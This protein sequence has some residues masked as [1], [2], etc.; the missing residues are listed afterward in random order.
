MYIIYYIKLKFIPLKT[1]IKK[2]YFVSSVYHAF[3]TPIVT[4]SGKRR[5]HSSRVFLLFRCGGRVWGGAKIQMLLNCFAN[6]PP[7][8]LLPVLKMRKKTAGKTLF[9]III[10]CILYSR[11]TRL[12]LCKKLYIN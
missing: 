5:R 8:L 10:I 6:S 9:F 7:G 4:N 1:N 11:S 12:L 2:A 3:Q